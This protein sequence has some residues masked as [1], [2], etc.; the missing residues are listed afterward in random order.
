MHEF[1][2]A[3]WIVTAAL[4][5]AEKADAGD[6]TA[7]YISLHPDSHLDP[8]SLAGAFEMAAAGTPAAGAT[9]EVAMD[10]SGRGEVAV[11]AIDTSGDR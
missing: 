6:L 11:T 7:V 3:N 4:D 9:L 8:D 1:S 5:A 2:L 10:G